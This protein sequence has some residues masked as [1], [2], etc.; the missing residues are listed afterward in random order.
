[1][2]HRLTARVD[3]LLCAV[4]IVVK[5]LLFQLRIHLSYLGFPIHDD[6]KYQDLSL[7]KA[8]AKEDITNIASIDGMR[9]V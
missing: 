2:L 7:A 9:F 3:V 1:M 5:W 8:D 4:L 6:E